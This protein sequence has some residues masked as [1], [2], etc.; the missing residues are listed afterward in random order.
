MKRIAI[1]WWGAAWLMVAATV[2]Q[3]L[4]EAWKQAEIHLFE[5]NT[6]LGNKIRISGWWRCNI[7]TGYYK[8]QDLETKYARGWEFLSHA[9]SQFWPRKMQ[10]RCAQ[11]D[12]PLV[13]QDDMR[14]FPASN[15]S[16]DVIDLFESILEAWNVHIHFSESVKTITKNKEKIPTDGDAPNI[17]FTVTTSKNT[18]EYDFVVITSWWNAH[19]E[20]W[21]TG[22]WYDLAKSLW[23]TI[24][25]LGP[26]LNSFLVEEEWIKQCSGISFSNATL[27]TKENKDNPNSSSNADNT[28]NSGNVKTSWPILFTHFGLSGPATFALSTHLPY[29]QISKNTPQTIYCKPFADRW[30]EWWIHFFT[31]KTQE[32]P[33][34]HLDTILEEYFPKRRV[35]NFLMHHFSH[36]NNNNSPKESNKA[37]SAIQ[38]ANLSNEQKKHLAH[39]LGD[40][41]PITL[42][43]RRP[44]DEFVTAGWV[45]TNEV[46]PKTMESLVCPWLFFAWEILNIDGVTWWFNFQAARSTWRCAGESLLSRISAF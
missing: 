30:Y 39:L 38:L 42:I 37:T 14:C 45:D 1:V 20:T 2:V 16:A 9:I 21:S 3:N 44:W 27:W 8:K 18:Y 23:H 31:A 43:A 22:D 6:Q 4:Q 13:C 29:I 5:K 10:Q 46:N 24:T 26:S 40:G 32:E 25:P 41:F 11:N 12:L 33:R 7:T 35:E 19:W 15:K 28:S 34:R 17:S 36:E